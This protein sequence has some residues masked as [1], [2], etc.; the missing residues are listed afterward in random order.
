[1]NLS[2][3]ARKFM[4]KIDL[5]KDEVSKEKIRKEIERLGMQDKLSGEYHKVYSYLDE[6]FSIPWNT[7]Q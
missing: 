3:Q 5:I 2:P 1:M 6:V 4:E 7:L